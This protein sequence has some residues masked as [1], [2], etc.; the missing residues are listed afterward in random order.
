ML[1]KGDPGLFYPHSWYDML[2]VLLIHVC[3]GACWTVKPL[4]C[5]HA[6]MSVCKRF[7]I[8]I[9]HNVMQ[10]VW[11]VLKTMCFIVV[12]EATKKDCF[13]CIMQKMCEVVTNYPLKKRVPAM[14]HTIHWQHAMY[15][16][17]CFIV[18]FSMKKWYVYFYILY[19]NLCNIRSRFVSIW[20]TFWNKPIEY[21]LFV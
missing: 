10:T 15:N 17:E 4:I 2:I 7:I 8:E 1:V 19:M 3:S 20:W 13:T 21:T 9:F 5:I 6:Y 18:V 16:F 14:N 11:H 12:Y